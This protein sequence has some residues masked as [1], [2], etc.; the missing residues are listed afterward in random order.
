MS[1]SAPK[2]GRHSTDTLERERFRC[3]ARD[4]PGTFACE[5]SDRVSQVWTPAVMLRLVPTHL[6]AE[7]A[8][9]T[10]SPLAWRSWS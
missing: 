3:G 2:Q 4:G 1:P 9:I 6:K 5:A 7:S 10:L 8:D